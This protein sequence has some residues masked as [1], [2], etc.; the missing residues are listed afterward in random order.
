MCIIYNSL[1]TGEKKNAALPSNI[2]V[3]GNPDEEQVLIYYTLI[4]VESR[5]NLFGV[6]FQESTYF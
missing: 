5:E 6:Q 3:W 1:R 4:T 2:I